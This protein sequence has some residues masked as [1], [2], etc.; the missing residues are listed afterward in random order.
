[1]GGDEFSETQRSLPGLSIAYRTYNSPGSSTQVSRPRFSLV[2]SVTF[3]LYRL[4]THPHYLLRSHGHH[5]LPWNYSKPGFSGD[6]GQSCCSLTY[7]VF[8]SSD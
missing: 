8:G 6:W 2:P 7:S 5:D 4:L 1:M 3:V